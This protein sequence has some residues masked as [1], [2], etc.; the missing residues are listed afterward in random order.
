MRSTP[1][2]LLSSAIAA[3]LLGFSSQ[4][5]VAGGE[6]HVTTT[7]LGSSI[8]SEHPDD[9]R[10]VLWLRQ[11]PEGTA[12]LAFDL[13]RLPRGIVVERAVLRLVARDVAY[14]PDGSPASRRVIV[15]ATLTDDS[16]NCPAP[17]AITWTSVVSLKTID[18]EGNQIAWN[19]QITNGARLRQELNERLETG[20]PSTV[21][22]L[23][24]YTATKD[25]S[26]LFTA[27]EPPKSVSS[28]NASQVPRLVIRYPAIPKSLL[29]TLS[30]TQYQ[31]NPEHT[32]RSAWAPF[33]TPKGFDLRHVEVKGGGGI[34]DYPLIWRGNL[35]LVYKVLDTNHLVALDF[36]GKELWRHEI[37]EGKVER[38]PVIGPGG[39]IYLSTEESIS[40]Y[41]LRAPGKPVY[42]YPLNGKASAYADLTIG[43]DGSLFVPLSEGGRG[44]IYGFTPDLKPFI[45]NRSY[46][47][48]DQRISTITASPDGGTLFAQTPKGAVLIDVANPIEIPP[49][50]PE[51]GVVRGDYYHAPVAGPETGAVV[52]SHYAKLGNHGQIWALR[53]GAP[54]ADRSGTLVPQPVLDT[55]GLVY[56]IEDGVLWGADFASPE[57]EWVRWPP[58]ASADPTGSPP[59]EANL[60]ATSNQVLD[61]ADNLYFWDNGILFLFP[62]GLSDY[63]QADFVSGDWEKDIERWGQEEK[64]LPEQFIRLV[65]GPDGTLWANDN[66]G[67]SLFAFVPTY[68]VEKNLTLKHKEDIRTQTVYRAENFL[69]AGAVTIEAG[70]NVLLQAD[71]GI[72]FAPKFKVE[73]GASLLA[74]ASPVGNRKLPCPAPPFAE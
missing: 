9:L 59:P 21:V 54:R 55:R 23:C 62:R 19:E 66:L 17:P 26:S 38:P 8:P 45:K 13:G 53:D 32:G 16:G 25:A 2:A 67:S 20:S 68:G 73:K 36:R 6:G 37:G 48:G 29:D 63:V 33:R 5:A 58:E 69:H 31:H 39:L 28:E 50:P 3:L 51:A 47:T 11:I 61:G 65:L 24:L 70:T 56:F 52:F 74:R 35:Y 60:N 7:L 44:Y 71:C 34:A 42:S 72:G 10:G 4:G 40:A 1:V 12:T 43:N 18:A 46:A 30:W 41:D 49:I 27:P 15:K 22:K 64:E 14:R 57:A